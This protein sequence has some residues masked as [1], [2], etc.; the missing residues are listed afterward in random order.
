LFKNR[1][2]RKEANDGN[3]IFK[4]HTGIRFSK[5][6]ASDRMPEGEKVVS[7]CSMKNAQ[8]RELKTTSG[9]QNT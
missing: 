7:F 2:I 9:L 6:I 5:R 3:A 8:W 4:S 1:A